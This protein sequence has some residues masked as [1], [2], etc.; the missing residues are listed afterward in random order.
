MNAFL[1]DLRREGSSNSN[2]VVRRDEVSENRKRDIAAYVFCGFVAIIVCLPIAAFVLLSF[3]KKYPVDM[4][5]SFVN[6][7]KTL[8][9][10]AGIYLK[11]S[12]AVV[13]LTSFIRTVVA[14]FSAYITAR[15]RKEISSRILRFISMLS[16]AIPGIVLGLSYVFTFHEMPFYR[17]MFILVMVNMIHFFASLYLM[18]Y[19]SLL[20]YSRSLEDV[21]DSLGIGRFQMLK[22]VYLPET[23]GNVLEM[24]S[25]FFVNC[26]I[27][28]SAVS[29]L[30]NFRT[31]PLTMLIPQLEA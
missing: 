21:A 7:K 4:T 24:Y 22:A 14:Y 16:M 27:T 15:S 2:T 23:F 9:S 5:I 26:M 1:F 13:L 30:A 25:Y 28:I 6:I 8:K 19:N 12:L 17:T 29:F 18:G 20:K 10:G 3:V 31:L 11:N